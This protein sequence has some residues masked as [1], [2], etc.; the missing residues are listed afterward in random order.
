[1]EIDLICRQTNYT[2]DEAKEKIAIYGCPIK[3]IEEYMKPPEK[4]PVIRNTHQQIYH[5]I[6]KFMEEKNR[7]HRIQQS[8]TST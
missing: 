2:E 4:V 1:M 5:E 3:V 8:R 6:S 7:L